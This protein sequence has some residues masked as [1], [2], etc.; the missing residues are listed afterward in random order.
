M[1]SKDKI[2]ELIDKCSQEADSINVDEQT[3]QLTEELKKEKIIEYI[4][5]S[6]DDLKFI[7]FID[8]MEEFN[9][10]SYENL[11]LTNQE[12]KEQKQVVDEKETTTRFVQ[13][14]TIDLDENILTK[15]KELLEDD[16]EPITTKH[17]SVNDTHDKHFKNKPVIINFDNVTMRYN[18]IDKLIEGLNLKIHEGEFIYL[19]GPSGSGKSTLSRLIY[20]DVKNIGGNVIVDG[21]NVTTLKPRHLHKLRKKIGVIFQDYKLL[22]DLTIYENVKYTLDVIGYPK[23]KKQEQVLKTLKKVGI[24][25]QK[26]KFPNELSGG[27][28][29]RA[30]IARAIVNEPKIIVADEPTGN[31]DPKNADIIMHILERINKAGTTVIMATHDVK[32]VNKYKH[33]TVKIESGCIQSE[34]K[35]GGYIYE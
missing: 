11:D 13:S 22:N 21:I 27:Q 18:K 16:Y 35:D 8:N 19:V 1:A 12:N 29:Q 2:E 6:S 31:L 3:H 17:T 9:V 26:D 14:S 33:R 30:A 10:G 25:E 4:D 15:S 23:H 24:F 7:D 32:I 5:Y 28:Q 20:R 34:N